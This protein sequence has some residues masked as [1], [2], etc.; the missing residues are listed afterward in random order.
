MHHKQILPRFFL[1][2]IDST[3]INS[4][5]NRPTG[6]FLVRNLVL[7]RSILMYRPYT[8]RTIYIQD[9]GRIFSFYYFS[10]LLIQK[11]LVR[12]VFQIGRFLKC[13]RRN[14]NYFSCTFQAV[15]MIT[16]L[17][18]SKLF[19]VVQRS[20][21][22]FLMYLVLNTNFRTMIHVSTIKISGFSIFQICTKPIFLA[23]IHFGTAFWFLYSKYYLV[24]VQVHRAQSFTCLLYTSPSPR[25]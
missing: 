21:E 12:Q 15:Q 4:F 16:C 13:L 7:G 6:Y 9:D 19:F 24:L 23:Y 3:F 25:D 5:I 22:K 10:T 2:A 14:F 8:A 11:I 17:H 20:G 18:F 1:K